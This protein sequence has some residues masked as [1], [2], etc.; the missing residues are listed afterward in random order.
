[1]FSI[2]FVLKSIDFA[3][4]S[5]D[6]H[7]KESRE[8]TGKDGAANEKP[9]NA[10]GLDAEDNTNGTAFPSEVARPFKF[11]ETSNKIDV[12]RFQLKSIQNVI[13]CQ[14]QT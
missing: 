5:I 11:L 9:A 14:F 6:F 2:D 13:I 7:L 8:A 1:M 4:F 12:K 10:A 3:S